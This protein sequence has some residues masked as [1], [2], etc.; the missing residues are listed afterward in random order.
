MN[1]KGEILTEDLGVERRKGRQ[2][3]AIALFKP[4]LFRE[5]HYMPCQVC[6]AKW[7]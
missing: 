6:R 7:L 2:L 5:L 4:G 1:L 3:Y